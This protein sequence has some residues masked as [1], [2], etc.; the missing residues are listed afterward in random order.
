MYKIEFWGIVFYKT[1]N[2][3]VYMGK[4][5]GGYEFWVTGRYGYKKMKGYGKKQRSNILIHGV[6]GVYLSTEEC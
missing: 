5:K 2:G 4:D 3:G 1:I 6:V